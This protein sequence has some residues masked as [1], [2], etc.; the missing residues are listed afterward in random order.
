MPSLTPFL[1][2]NDQAEAAAERY[3]E[4]FGGSI[5][6][7]GQGVRFEILGREYIAFNG[8]SYH[9]LTPAFSMMVTVT[10][11]AEIDRYWDALLAGGGAPSRCGWLEDR[12]GLSWQIVPDVLGDLLGSD[13]DAASGRALQAMLG[14]EKLDVAQLQRAFDGP[15]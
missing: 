3:V 1:W 10:T 15:A 11:Q 9:Q 12:F 5:V 6:E 13:D 4:I 2:F 7:R 14:M 8:G